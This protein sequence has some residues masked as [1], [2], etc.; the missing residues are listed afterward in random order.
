MPF[1]PVLVVCLL[2][3]ALYCLLGWLVS[4]YPAFADFVEGDKILLYSNGQF[5]G[6]NLRRTQVCREGAL[7]DGLKQIDR[8]YMERK[9]EISALKK[10][11]Y[12]NN[13]CFY[14]TNLKTN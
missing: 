3:S 5:I 2:I 9:G 11:R 14:L 1:Q 13:N 8:L 10:L 6:K 7:T 4:A 12:W